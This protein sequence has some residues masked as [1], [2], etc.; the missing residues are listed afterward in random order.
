LL[1]HEKEFVRIGNVSTA[2]KNLLAG[3][4][5]PAAACGISRSLAQKLRKA[6]KA[7]IEDNS[8]SFLPGLSVHRRNTKDDKRKLLI[9]KTSIGV[10]CEGQLINFMPYKGS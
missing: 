8:G 1:I 4:Q 9:L 7:L 5:K 10:W 6:R 2:E 3:I